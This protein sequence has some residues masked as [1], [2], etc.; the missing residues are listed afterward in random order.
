MYYSYSYCGGVDIFSYMRLDNEELVDELINQCY[1]STIE[2]IKNLPSEYNPPAVVIAEDIGFNK[3]T[4]FAPNYLRSV[5]FERLKTIVGMY[6]ERGIKVILHSDGDLRTVM[7]DIVNI[8]ITEI[9]CESI[10]AI[11]ILNIFDCLCRFI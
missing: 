9:G 1:L 8:G 10:A 2:Y 11:L 6:H 4:L 7:D 3:G 5:L